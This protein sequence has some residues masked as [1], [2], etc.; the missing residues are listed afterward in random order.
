[1]ARVSRLAG[2]L[3]LE[4]EGRFFIVGN[5]KEPCDWSAHGFRDPG[6]IDA[7]R[8]PYR[9]LLSSGSPD[10]PGL[11]L[12]LPRE[13]EALAN[14]LSERLVIKRN[15][16]VS[17]RLWNLIS[18]SVAR[19]PLDVIEARWLVELPEGIWNIVRNTVLRCT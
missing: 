13:G 17:E 8:E 10:L 2:A 3:I 11:A 5:P 6:V 9:E 1:M 14:E 18:E 12:A 15:G 4:T 7:V 16:S 19:Q